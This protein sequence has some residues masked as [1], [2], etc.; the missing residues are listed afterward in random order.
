MQFKSGKDQKTQTVN[1][2]K[3]IEIL[4]ELKHLSNE[5]Y[6]KLYSDLHKYFEFNQWVHSLNLDILQFYLHPTDITIDNLPINSEM[7]LYD[8]NFRELISRWSYLLG[9]QKQLSVHVKHRL[10]K[11]NH[12]LFCN[13]KMM[14]HILT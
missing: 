7:P 10:T 4:N 3:T 14:E 11:S 5:L 12:F 2:I 8:I 9:M 1:Q 6:E 13:I